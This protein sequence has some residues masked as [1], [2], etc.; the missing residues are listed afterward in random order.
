MKP[1]FSYGEEEEEDIVKVL[2]GCCGCRRI[3]FYWSEVTEVLGEDIQKKNE[4]KGRQAKGDKWPS[5][6][7]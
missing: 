2:G 1:G 4:Q 5:R 7:T 6:G 3:C